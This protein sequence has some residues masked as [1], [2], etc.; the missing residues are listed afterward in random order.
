MAGSV[1]NPTAATTQPYASETTRIRTS[2]TGRLKSYKELFWV[3]F[4]KVGLK[5]GY[6]ED[7]LG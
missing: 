5:H 1:V 7:D 2:A 3:P 4:V 6:A